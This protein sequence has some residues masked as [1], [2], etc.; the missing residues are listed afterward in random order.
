MTEIAAALHARGHAG[1]GADGVGDPPRRG[2]RAPRA[3]RAAARPR[4]SSRSKAHAPRRGRREPRSPATTPGSTCSCRRMVE[5]GLDAL[6]SAAPAIPGTSVLSLVPL[7]SAR[8]CCSSAR[9]RGRAANAFPLGGRPRAR[10]PARAR[11]PSP[12]PP[13]SPATPTGCERS[14][15]VALLEGL[16]RRCGEVGLYSGE[17]GFN[18]DFH[19]IRHHGDGGPARRSTTCRPRSQ[20]TRSVLTFFAQDHAS[21]EMVYANA[22]LTK[23]EQAHEVVAFAEYWQRVVGRRPGLLCFDSQLT[24]YAMLDELCARGITFLTL[25]QRGK[26]VLEALAALPASAWTT[27]TSSGPAATGAPRSTRRSCSLKG[28]EPSAAPDRRSGTSATKSPPCSSP[29]TSPPP[30][31]RTSSPATPS[32]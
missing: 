11:R 19:A 2:D 29:T 5:L 6:V 15:N 1:V 10:A 7:A 28:V 26:K 25:R 27:H 23:A 20:R 31:A 4:A 9:R 13:T 21:T 22:D 32:G 14:S 12:R 8:T 3:P 18:L 30:P 16:A 17:A 24:T